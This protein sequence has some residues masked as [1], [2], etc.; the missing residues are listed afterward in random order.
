MVSFPYCPPQSLSSIWGHLA[1][2]GCQTPRF[3]PNSTL[4]Q[5]D[6][7]PVL[8]EAWSS[9]PTSSPPFNHQPGSCLSCLGR[10][11]APEMEQE[12][13]KRDTW[14]LEEEMGEQVCIVGVGRKWMGQ[15]WAGI[16]QETG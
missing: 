16:I 5:P 15:D 14:E 4:G 8:L 2:R 12:R 3:F 11:P 10:A 9:H 7:S 1:T 13:T 6:F